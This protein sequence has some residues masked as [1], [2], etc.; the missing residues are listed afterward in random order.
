M[1]LGAGIKDF[2]KELFVLE[3][4]PLPKVVQVQHTQQNSFNKRNCNNHNN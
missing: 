1:N 3:K 4:K 2:M